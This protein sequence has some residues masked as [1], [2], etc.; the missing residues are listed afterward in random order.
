MNVNRRDTAG[1]G[2]PSLVFV[3]VTNAHA[4]VRL[5]SKRRKESE[6]TLLH[7]QLGIITR[8]PYLPLWESVDD[9]S[10]TCAAGG[11]EVV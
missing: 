10:Y 2:R 5:A 6:R 1:V 7:L 3:V 9:K 8:A 4:A 11:Y